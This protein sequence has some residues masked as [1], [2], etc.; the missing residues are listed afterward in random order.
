FANLSYN[1]LLYYPSPS[2]S[3]GMHDAELRVY[4]LAGNNATEAWSFR[5]DDIPPTVTET[6]PLN[7][8]VITDRTLTISATLFDNLEVKPDSVKLRVDGV[9]RTSQAV[10]TKTS[11]SCQLI[12]D[13][14]V[15]TAEITLADT[16]DNFNTVTWTFTIKEPEPLP[17][18][19][20]RDIIIMAVLVVAVVAVLLLVFMMG[21]RRRQRY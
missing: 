15:H 21:N 6:K 19:M 17:P 18:E 10:I 8:S 5:V 20:I 11:A 9:D 2:L 7:G 12:L 4:D 3:K 16:S 13:L 1:A 14:G